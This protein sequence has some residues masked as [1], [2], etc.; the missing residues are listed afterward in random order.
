MSVRP[1]EVEALAFTDREH[2][3]SVDLGHDAIFLDVDGTL[4]DIARS[5]K[6]VHVSSELRS[7]LAAIASNADSA[8]AL[9]SGR[10]VESVDAL[11]AP[12]RTATIGCHG[13]QMRRSANAVTDTRVAPLPD[14]VR[15]AFSD[16]VKLFPRVEFE[17]KTFALAF[18]Y[19]Q[20]PELRG[21]LLEHLLARVAAFEADYVM[22]SGKSVFEI[23]PKSCTKGEALRELMGGPPFAGRRPIF[24]GDDTTDEYAFAILPEFG[25][26]GVSVGRAVASVEFT[27]PSP[28]HVRHW[29]SAL[30]GRCE[31]RGSE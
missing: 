6:H 27:V 25:G 11:F 12:W 20:A 31:V 2:L 30:A 1:D 16:M 15:S 21:P 9:V 3:P 10:T 23:R 17:D 4:V 13:A 28:R 18:H 29:L 24:F 26:I 19:R 5:P 8:L 14:A 22:M 7:S